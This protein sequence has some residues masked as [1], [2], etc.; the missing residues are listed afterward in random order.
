MS[1]A[2]A[3]PLEPVFDENGWFQDDDEPAPRVAD[4]CLLVEGTY[5]FV[6]GGV[7][8]WVHDIIRGMPERTFDVLNIGSH[9]G[10]FT[11]PRY[12]LPSNVLTLRCL[13]CRDE[14]LPLVGHAERTELDQH[15]RSHRR[16]ASQPSSS[17]VLNAIRRLHLDDRI[18]DALV[19]DLAAGD[20]GVPTFLHG[21][22]SFDLLLEIGQHLAPVT[23]FLDLF[24]QFR[25]MHVPLL[26]LLSAPTPAA[27]CYHAVSTGYA[28]LLGAVWGLRTGRPF[29]VTEHG[30]YTRER[31]MELARATWIRDDEG[32][33]DR[34]SAFAPT[35]SA[36]R[37]LWAR[38]FRKL[39]TVAYHRASHIITLSEANRRKQI[40]DGAP[41]AKIQI[42]PNG[43]ALAATGPAPPPGPEPAHGPAPHGSATP[44]ETAAAAAP[45][46][47][48]FVGRVVPIKD[49]ITFIKACDLALREMPL[50]VRIIGPFDEEPT[51]AARCRALIKMLGREDSIRFLGP[52][53][54]ALIYQQI[55]V[56]VL[57]SYSEGQPLV[58]LEAYA[59]GIPVVATDVGACREMIEGMPGPDQALGPS[60]LVTRVATP[61]DTAAALLRLASDTLLRRR[62][63][64]AGRARVTAHYQRH[65]MLESY[66][67]LYRTLVEAKPWQE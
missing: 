47:V 54:P 62:L 41:A 64:R 6:S 27:R 29:A 43:V 31:E 3:R 51:Y 25:A 53:P 22:A 16:G 40:N 61:R 58:I 57:T 26:R 23:S 49:V 38:F 24:W 60:G 10:A 66:R 52:M 67:A 19:A 44:S 14:E 42:V 8:S 65:D 32:A 46:R 50:D 56:I 2:E 13:F 35:P 18:D 34:L 12:E 11:K 4:V 28:G 37:Q 39:A 20:L 1:V 5:P 9:A 59:A 48:G 21:G 55:D 30:I 45:L 33:P 7:S 17:R 15:I 36:L 63:G